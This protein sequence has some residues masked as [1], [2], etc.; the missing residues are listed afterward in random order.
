MNTS[1]HINRIPVDFDPFAG[2][3]IEQIAPITESQAEIW[4][5]CQ[6]GGEEASRAYN[7]S[8]SLR[9]CGPLNRQA[10]ERA[11]QTLIQHHEGT[12]CAF[13]GD[14]SQ[15]LIFETI[16]PPLSILDGSTLTAT[17]QQGQIEQV[18]LDD[19]HHTFDLLNGPLLKA[20]LIC[21]SDNEHHFTLTGHH[22]VCDGWSIGVLLQDL[23]T[24]YSAYGQRGWK[25]GQMPPLA[26][27]DSIIR[28]AHEQQAFAQ[29]PAFA[30][31]ERFWQQ[32]H[33]PLPPVLN[34]PTDFPRPT[35]RTFAC[36]RQD[37]PMD[38]LLLTNI[39][40]LGLRMG[41][42]FATTLVSAYELWLHQLTSQ[43][44]LVLGM[45]AAGQAAT[46]HP[47]LVGHCV[48]LLPLRSCMQ[49]N[50]SFASYLSRRK[51]ELIDALD[52]QKLTLGRLIQTLAIPRDS[53]RVPLVSAVFNIDMGVGEGMTF[54]GLQH[55]FISNPH[56]YENFE[57][58]VNA[59]GNQD[60]LCLQW[61]YNVGLF[62]PETI[63]GFHQQF[64]QLLE[65]VIADPSAPLTNVPP[66]YQVETS[67][68][69]YPKQPL[70]HLLSET[71]RTYP[72]KVAVRFDGK[73]LTY[74]ELHRQANQLAQLL[75][76]KG[77]RPGDRVGLSID[78]SLEL[79]VSLLAVMKAGGQYIPTDPLHPT[80][81][82][83]YVIADADCS[84]L[85]T[86]RAYAGR[87]ELPLAE[88]LIETIWPTLNTY[89][90]TEPDITVAAD[91]PIYVLYTS[92]TTG[93]PKGVQIRHDSVVNVLYGLA[94]KPG[95]TATD[96]TVTMGT[97]AFDITTAEIYLPLLVGAEL[98]VVG[99]DTVR[100]GQALTALF[101][102]E[103]ITFVQ[104]TPATLRML[105]E[106]GWRGN[107][108]LRVISCAEALPTDLAQKLLATCAALYNYYGPTETTVYATGTQI[109]SAEGPITIGLPIDN[110][111]VV[112]VDQQL[113]PVADGQ[114][115]ELIIG[116][117]GVGSGYLN[118]PDLTDAKFIRPAF[119]PTERFYR[120]GDLA[121]RLPTGDIQYLGRID[122]QIKIRGHRIEPGEVEFHLIRL[123]E[124]ENA[125]VVAR[126]DQPSHQR[127]VAYMVLNNVG[128]DARI[129]REQVLR[130]RTTLATVLPA[131]MIPSDFVIMSQL[132]VTPNGKLDRKALPAPEQTLPTPVMPNLTL[133]STPQ[134]KQIAA[135]W[136]Q[137]FRLTAVGIDDNFF[138]LGGHSMLAV[139][140][141]IQ[142]ERETGRRLPVSTLFESPTIRS[143]ARLIGPDQSIDLKNSLVPI[144]PYGSKTPLY[145]V[146]GGGLNLLTFRGLVD[147]MD[148]EQP[149]YG[150]Q[151]RG[152]DGTE[153]PLDTMEAIA[154]D[155]IEELLEHNP[156]GPYS[157]AG[158]SF[159][160][161]VALEMACQLQQV[162]KTVKLLGMFD[163][164]AED[165]AEGR[166]FLD[167]LA[168][169]IGRQFPKLLWIAR[170][171]I[172]QP[173]PTLRY[174][175]EYLE[176]QVKNV[177]KT[178]GLAT[179]QTYAEIQD[180]NLIRIIEK[181]EI[182]L[183]NYRM[184]P[185]DG[186]IDVFKA[187]KRLYFVEDR[188]FLGWKKYARQG[189]RIYNVPGDHKEMLLPP[190]DK[191][192]ALILQKALDQSQV[193]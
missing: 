13:S 72:D 122:A 52:N 127:L 6:L 117:A 77:V 23:A 91:A 106:T 174:Q 166:P 53:A 68:V 10:F 171:F 165:S 133:P 111:H 95:L 56:A 20:S 59:M 116:G 90:S 103:H 17:E 55:E 188:E 54:A 75:I 15:V 130:W 137:V 102:R 21:L 153:E 33:Q 172:Q 132:P 61:T 80:D 16:A 28:Y 71:A 129:D 38:A 51:I 4:T 107:P 63:A 144:K 118:Q 57:L 180:E 193:S 142:L 44:D 190:N 148:A 30:R 14:G 140:V 11:W 58:S 186:V 5:A 40:T 50:D 120:T 113:Q 25:L 154:A 48:N 62:R 121:K 101:E 12:R 141:M 35:R 155:Y 49:P 81:R 128:R 34:L 147:Y 2:P 182:A 66:A 85:L 159:G 29:S 83:Q 134:E 86:N 99:A 42:S 112:V 158:Y 7:E 173:L 65:Q 169:R 84:I 161:Y 108:N 119:R 37:Y 32:L 22:I 124:V 157:L 187:N 1:I 156:D 69:T 125:V 114:A 82:I 178:V 184:K 98:V 146:H 67:S 192:F 79:V 160:G 104:T 151:A 8:V 36:K 181:H 70:H 191:E 94:R 138:D 167:R 27:A 105:W 24:L 143:L 164:N 185:Y 9:L 149:I 78:R 3:P 150:F 189:V 26:P 115:G 110:A 76:E 93:R 97:I 64:V 131:Y 177:L 41:N 43:L 39:R 162:G 31:I 163:T 145:V 109:L 92:G 47:R 176:R 175:G 60:S 139:R 96:K 135:I 136:Q 100:N 123:E 73:S 87:I 179:D 46:G 89:A 45:P 74:K 168:W 126:E 18:I 88:L 183:Q 170:S 152:L 19:A